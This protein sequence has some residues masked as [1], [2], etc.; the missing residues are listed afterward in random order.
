MREKEPRREPSLTALSQLAGVRALFLPY[1]PILNFFS[2]AN[3]FNF[4]EASHTGL[5]TVP[6]PLRQAKKSTTLLHVFTRVG[7]GAH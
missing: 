2:S 6:R 7:Y 4:F 3:L 1:V 5:I